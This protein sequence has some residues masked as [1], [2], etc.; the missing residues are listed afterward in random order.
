MNRLG[1]AP[2]VAWPLL[3]GYNLTDDRAMLDCA[4]AAM[5]WHIEHPDRYEVSH[6]VGPLTAARLNAEYGCALDLAPRCGCAA[7]PEAR[8]VGA[9][10]AGAARTP[11]ADKQSGT[12]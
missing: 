8:C 6:V 4:R 12:V 10:L 9:H 11:L 1:H 2:S 5:Q 3:V 7:Q